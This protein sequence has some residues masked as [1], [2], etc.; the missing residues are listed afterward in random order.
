VFGPT[1][2]TVLVQ[3]E[4]GVGKEVVATALHRRSGRT[5]RFVPVNVAAIPS[6]LLEA[7]LFGSVRGAFTG[8]T[9]SRPG[10]V[11]AAN[12]GTLFLDEVGDLSPQLQAKMLRFLESREVRAVGSTTFERVDVRVL[13]ATHRDLRTGIEHGWF[14]SDLFYRLA[15][16]AVEVPPLRHRAEDIGPF[17][18]LFEAEVRRRVGLA[19]CRWSAAAER[20]LARYPWPG[21]VRELRHVVE[22]AVVKAAG[23][24]VTAD[25][26]SLAPGCP[27][28]S[29]RWAEA[30]HDFRR[31]F[32]RAALRRNAGNRTATARELGISRQTLHYHL[33]Q[34]GLRD[35]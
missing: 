2:L 15:S 3:G 18:A 20:A 12:G 8:A 10:L 32:L 26:L 25:T 33:R 30:M 24:I 22:V 34:L 27:A 14:R 29:G 17:R 1:D 31:S 28:P 23:G 19:G 7:E 6:D 35:C 11:R 16:T 9:R 5:G 21:N 13:S 4:T